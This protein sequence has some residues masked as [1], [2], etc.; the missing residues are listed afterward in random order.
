[1]EVEAE[2]VYLG[3]IAHADFIV[4]GFPGNGI[5]V[6]N[7]RLILVR[8]SFGF[9]FGLLGSVT[10]LGAERTGRLS[11][12]AGRSRIRQLEKKMYFDA[13]KRD[14]ACLEMKVPDRTGLSRLRIIP[15]SGEPM[16]VSLNSVRDY[17]VVKTLMNL[18]YSEI[19]RI[20]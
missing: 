15:K 5:H 19:V 7:R 14:L 18:F 9:G 3:G 13:Y 2:E 10:S 8:S 16:E 1:M 17:E 20:I 11:G 4:M 6:T 12:K